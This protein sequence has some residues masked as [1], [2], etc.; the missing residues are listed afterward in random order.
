MEDGNGYS[1]CMK[2]NATRIAEGESCKGLQRNC[3]E[4]LICKRNKNKKERTCMV[5]VKA[6]EDCTNSEFRNPCDKKMRCH[7]KRKCAL[8]GRGTEGEMETERWRAKHSDV[9]SVQFL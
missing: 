7:K 6:G 3:E 2:A 5:P 9:K 1:F 4:G 8:R